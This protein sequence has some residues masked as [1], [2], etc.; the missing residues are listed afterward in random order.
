MSFFD[1]VFAVDLPGHETSRRF[2]LSFGIVA[3]VRW[4]DLKQ[5]RQT[6]RSGGPHEGTRKT[7]RSG[8]FFL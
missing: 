1:G 2:Y 5:R 7:S 4:G 6:S 3:G 8:F